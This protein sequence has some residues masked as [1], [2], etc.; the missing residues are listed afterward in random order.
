MAVQFMLLQRDLKQVAQLL[1]ADNV[2]RLQRGRHLIVLGDLGLELG[3]DFDRIL[4]HRINEPSRLAV[5][6]G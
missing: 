5:G 4:R 3:L 1:G 2:G 6:L